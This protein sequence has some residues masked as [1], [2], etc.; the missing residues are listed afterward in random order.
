MPLTDD[1]ITAAN[2]PSRADGAVKII[3]A[4]TPWILTG[5]ALLGAYLGVQEF[6]MPTEPIT[7]DTP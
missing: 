1:E 6:T 7:E 2:T 5:L 3:R 4:L